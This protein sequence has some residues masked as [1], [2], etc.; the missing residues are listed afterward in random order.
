MLDVFDPDEADSPMVVEVP[1]AGTMLPAPWAT[2]I[3]TDAT[4]VLR[5]ADS[6]VDELVLDAPSAGAALLRANV[7]RHVL[8]LNRSRDEYDGQAVEG[9][10]AHLCLPHGLIWHTNS[11][12]DPLMRAPI[13]EADAQSRIR[14]I[15]DPYHAELER[16]MRRSL[17]RNGVAL[18]LA[19][20]SMPSHGANRKGLPRRA[21][22][23]PGT[24]NFTSATPSLIKIVE[25][26][27]RGEGLTLS[28]DD[29][30]RGGWVT[31]LWGRPGLNCHAIQLEFCRDLYMDEATLERNSGKLQALRASCAT[32]MKRLSGAARLLAK[33]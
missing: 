26:W 16:L 13:S 33:H 4:S 7:S 31:K 19:V 15:Y 17:D 21:D 32:L 30:Y 12:G 24:Q 14:A 5:D 6:F 20:H 22:V 1:H 11:Q 29:P 10:P 25:E 23:V 3:L 18:V 2:G 27:A 8:D 28:H 9:A